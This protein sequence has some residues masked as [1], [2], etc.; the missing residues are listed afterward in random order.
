[1][2]SP[3]AQ[4][5]GR[6]LRGF[7][8][9]AGKTQRE[10][11]DELNVGATYVSQLVNGKVNWVR[12]GYFSA[13]VRALNVPPDTARALDPRP[14]AVFADQRPPPTPVPDALAAAA[15]Q[16]GGTFPELRSA[17]WQA[18]LAAL[19]WQ[20]G[21]PQTPDAWFTVFYQL[22]T[23]GVAPSPGP[24]GPQAGSGA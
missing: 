11:A 9:A 10:L 23:L 15:A 4:A 5:L 20:S 21:P 8:R 14:W 24:A 19:H 22:R 18:Y 16:Y 6:Q 2:T 1:M 17:A 7:L 3:D 13:I 12:S